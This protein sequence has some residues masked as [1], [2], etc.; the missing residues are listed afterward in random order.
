MTL[1]CLERNAVEVPINGARDFELAIDIESASIRTFGTCGAWSCRPHQ[2]LEPGKV[3]SNI[4][5]VEG[6]ACV[7]HDP[8]LALGKFSCIRRA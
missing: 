3:L 1:A 7:S 5:A 2:V 8:D 4:D 6:G